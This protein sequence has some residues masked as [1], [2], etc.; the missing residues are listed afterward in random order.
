MTEHR[1]S[2]N[3]LLVNADIFKWTPH[4]YVGWLPYLQAY[5]I[6]CEKLKHNTEN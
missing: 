1:D 6:F 2:E 5:G 3:I 4:K